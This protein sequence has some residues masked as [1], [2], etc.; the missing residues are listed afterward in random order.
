KAVDI[1]GDILQ[2]SLLEE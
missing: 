2:N 1:L